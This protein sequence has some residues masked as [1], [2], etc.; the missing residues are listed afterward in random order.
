VE[1]DGHLYE[2]DGRKPFPI[3]HGASAPDTLLTVRACA[4]GPYMRS[5]PTPLI[6]L[7]WLRAARGRQDAA[8]AIRG[9][10]ERDPSNLQF[11]MVAL[12]PASDV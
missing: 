6:G 10:M 3:N 9:F 5:P 12:C 2:L 1:R 11:T 4:D 8:R 7:T